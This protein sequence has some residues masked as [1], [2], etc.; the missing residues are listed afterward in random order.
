MRTLKLSALSLLVLPAAFSSTLGYNVDLD[1]AGLTQGGSYFVDLQL[2]GSNANVVNLS[3]FSYGGGNGPGGPFTLA[4]TTNFF[5]QDVEAF[6]A[7]S[8]LSFTI[9]ST[10]LA[11]P[12][13]GFPDELSFY[14]LNSSHNPLP[15]SDPGSALFYLDIN[16]ANPVIQTFD[17]PGI[18]APT[19]TP[20]S[21]PEPGT[22]WL[23]TSGLS[24]SLLGTSRWV[25][26]KKAPMSRTAEKTMPAPCARLSRFV[27]MPKLGSILIL[28]FL[29]GAACARAQLVA[30][31]PVLSCYQSQGIAFFGYTN[32]NADIATVPIGS[33]NFFLQFPLDQGQP[34]T[35]YSGDHND[36]FA[37]VSDP[38]AGLTW[39]VDNGFADASATPLNQVCPAA[40]TGPEFGPIGLAAGQTM[41][42][43]VTGNDSCTAILGFA[44]STGTP[45]GPSSAA[46]TLTNGQVG[47]LDLTAASL[48]L[49]TGHGMEIQPQIKAGFNVKLACQPTVEIFGSSSGAG[50]VIHHPQTPQIQPVFPAQGLSEGQTLRVSVA[51]PAGYTCSARMGFSDAN[52][53]TIGPA[54]SVALTSGNLASLDLPSTLV[55][56]LKGWTGTRAEFRP[57]L[58][59]LGSP[60]VAAQGVI[61][62]V[63]FEQTSYPSL[64]N[65]CLATAEVLDTFSAATRLISNPEGLP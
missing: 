29:G 65:V 22:S 38:S 55:P 5:N 56:G 19:I 27:P 41:R 62:P 10:N 51:A 53:K 23:L 48:H 35:F 20:A 57:N 43:K 39:S 11:P 13:G 15:T 58:T 14:L 3:S 63:T 16:G 49:T 33:N 31:T 12:P 37:V 44:D 60:Q 6:T 26:R 18:R 36:V 50:L 30:V 34:T 25:R 9:T 54:S 2:V 46:V 52:N 1:T 42:L 7:G 61:D 32:I 64:A 59:M 17:G 24:F 21:T 4:T 40:V 28:A 8:L 45:I 47:Y